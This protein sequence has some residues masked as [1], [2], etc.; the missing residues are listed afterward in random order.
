MNEFEFI[1]SI[2]EKLKRSK[3]H[4]RKTNIADLKN[5]TE[6]EDLVNLV[7]EILKNHEVHECI[8]KSQIQFYA[9]YI[10]NITPPISDKK[11]S[12]LIF[13]KCFPKP[14][15]K[16]Y[17]HFTST[18]SLLNIL[19]T[20]QIRLYNL[21]KRFKDGEF[22][23]FYTDH[24][25]DGYKNGG[26]VLGIDC[27]EKSIMSEIYIFS[28]TSQGFDFEGQSKWKDFGD[29]GR[30]FR[31]EFEIKSKHNDFREV[32]YS[33]KHLLNNIPLLKDLFTKIK[34]RYDLPFNFTYSSKI[35]AFYIKGNFNNESE[36]RFLIKRLSD[37]Y[38]AFYLKPIIENTQ[39]NINYI[40][41][42]FSS[43]FADFKIKSIQPGYH[44][45]EKDI[46]KVK[47]L[48][49]KLK[50][51]VVIHPKANSENYY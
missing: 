46:S 34:N 20:K 14:S 7:N 42:P 3:E 33:R 4:D 12:H 1:L 39:E 24:G 41:I 5:K 35:G 45:I 51:S 38:N 2:Q 27:S 49:K 17:Y 21:R 18:K 40:E 48:I 50:P 44:C 6:I 16:T 29:N 8:N 23:E 36:Y 26:E 13:E 15:L 25:M 43:E 37:D 32:Y 9:D 10:G 19:E 22:T 30:G 28:L 11:L 47:Y 31:I